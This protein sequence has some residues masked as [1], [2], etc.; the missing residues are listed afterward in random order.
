M[1]AS[2]QRIRRLPTGTPS[3]LERD[4]RR[5]QVADLIQDTVP[6]TATSSVHLSPLSVKSNRY[7]WAHR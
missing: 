7:C 2:F 6:D 3:L 5:D 4:L 1:S